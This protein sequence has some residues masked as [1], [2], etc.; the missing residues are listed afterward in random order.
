MSKS[1]KPTYIR[2]AIYT[3][4]STEEGLDQEFNS[5]DAQREAGE[6]YIASQKHEGW[7]CVPDHFDDGG[8]SGGNTDRPGLTKLMAEVEAGRVNCIVVYKV[9]RL[10]RSLLDF[11]KIM[12]VLDRHG[13]S[14]V[15]VTQQFN[16]T[17][18]MGRLTLNILLSFAQFEREVIGERIRD[19]IGAA[20]R[21]GKW[22]GGLPPLGY[23]V[24][25]MG[26][27][28]VVNKREAEHVKKI[29]ELYLE[30]K[31]MI[32]V[33]KELKKLGIV[34]K[35]HTSRSGNQRGGKPIGSN[36]LH[37][38]IHNFL[39]VGKIR[40]KDN[41]YDGEHEAIIDE[42]TFNRAQEI[43]KNNRVHITKVNRKPNGAA[44]LS[45]LLYCEHCGTPMTMSTTVKDKTK[46]YRY[47]VCNHARQHGWNTCPTRSIPAP[48]IEKFIYEHISSIGANRTIRQQVY[49]NLIAEDAEY[50]QEL[51]GQ[52]RAMDCDMKRYRREIQLL[53]AQNTPEAANK[54]SQIEK[55]LSS[56]G[57]QMQEIRYLLKLRE[58]NPLTEGEVNS[59]IS[60]FEA[61]WDNLNAREKN[62]MLRLLIE[63]ITFNGE[64]GDIAVSL[65]P[66]AARMLGNQNHVTEAV[67]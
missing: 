64:T 49:E 41:I 42:E 24:D 5:L 46:H 14:F 40:H 60:E 12:E 57:S 61:V 4:K 39:Y 15:S 31:S 63:R 32:T 8:F 48:E 9:D 47:Y 22:T 51:E 58:K 55:Q 3:R 65:R 30:H 19:K 66:Q 38:I 29:F 6:S 28:I 21:R 50:Q 20:K 37:E 11:T 18:S 33:C 16:T 7:E 25:P 62:K 36:R 13:C 2:C 54:T 59:T 43:I 26:R 35:K 45:H 53:A 52:L 44:I 23:D 10:S 27:K 34:S 67:A 1:D 56:V 17:N